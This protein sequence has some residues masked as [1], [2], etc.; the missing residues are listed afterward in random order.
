MIF[1]AKPCEGNRGGGL[2]VPHNALNV[3]LHSFMELER[4]TVSGMCFEAHCITEQLYISDVWTAGSV[5][6]SRT[7]YSY[8]L[9]SSNAAS[10]ALR[11][12]LNSSTSSS[13]ITRPE[14]E[15]EI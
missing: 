3:L 10:F 7:T 14:P 9:R 11:H 4:I 13:P 15:V 6:L 1:P 2:T 8:L 5:A 12:S